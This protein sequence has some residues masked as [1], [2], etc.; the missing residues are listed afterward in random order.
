MTD[1]KITLEYQMS[2]AEYLAATRLLFFQTKQGMLRLVVVCVLALVAALMMSMF[3]A[4]MFA[5]VITLVFVILFDVVLFY[6]ALVTLPRRFYRGDPKFREKYQVTFSNE[7][8]VVKTFQIDS[9][10]AW[11]LYTKVI[12]GREMYLLMYGKDLR[13]MTAVPKRVFRS[14]DEEME[15][16]GLVSRHI[17]DHSAFTNIPPEERGYTPKS[18]TPPDWR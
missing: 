18:L 11:S 10:L 15:F 12:E 1:S 7:G 4:D 5:L 3:L 13:M 14:R 9:K 8:V 17:A 2:E 6:N 16:R